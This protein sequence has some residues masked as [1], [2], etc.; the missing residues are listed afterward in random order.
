MSKQTADGERNRRASRGERLCEKDK[1]TQRS[2]PG[3][4]KRAPLELISKD[5]ALSSPKNWWTNEDQG[6][7]TAIHLQLCP[8][9]V[10][11]PICSTAGSC[12]AVHL[13]SKLLRR[14]G[15]PMATGL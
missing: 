1:R 10:S 8:Q 13:N 12:Q 7:S 2:T 15:G 14:G 3:S 6:T 4:S 9:F 11:Q 5:A